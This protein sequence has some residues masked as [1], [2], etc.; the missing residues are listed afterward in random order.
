VC[1]RKS[2][3]VKKAAPSVA[4]GVSLAASVGVTQA[5]LNI[6]QEIGNHR[7]R[8]IYSPRTIVMDSV[9]IHAKVIRLNRLSHTRHLAKALVMTGLRMNGKAGY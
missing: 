7:P 9:S 5:F 6:V 8:P 3:Q 2:R 4:A 1:C